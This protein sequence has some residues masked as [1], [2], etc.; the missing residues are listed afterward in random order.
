M[1]YKNNPLGI[2][3][4]TLKYNEYD[5]Q[6]VQLLFYSHYFLYQIRI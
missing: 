1:T 5:M 2:V 3:L 6:T 4:E